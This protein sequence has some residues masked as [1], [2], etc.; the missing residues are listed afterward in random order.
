MQWKFCFAKGT[1][2]T[3]WSENERDSIQPGLWQDQILIVATFCFRNRQPA[4]LWKEGIYFNRNCSNPH[5]TACNRLG[6]KDHPRVPSPWRQE[7]GCRN[8]EASSQILIHDNRWSPGPR[9]PT[10][11]F[12]L[13]ELAGHT[14]TSK[15]SRTEHGRTQEPF[16][17]PWP[18]LATFTG[19]LDLWLVRIKTTSLLCFTGSWVF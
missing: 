12:F 3:L 4:K 5:K 15:S 10:L 17:S 14:D 6:P 8:R 18:Q 2:L 9:V 11:F 19:P 16:T 1:S 13:T 7:T